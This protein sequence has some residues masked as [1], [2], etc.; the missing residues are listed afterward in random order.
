MVV[1]NESTL[2]HDIFETLY[3]LAT[4]ITY[5][6]SVEPTITAAF[7]DGAH[8]PFP[9][10]VVEPIDVNVDMIMLG[11]REAN[12]TKMR[13]I[14]ASIIIYT[15]KNEDLDLISDKLDTSVINTQITGI[16]LIDSA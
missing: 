4:A 10:I 14:N 15:K 13:T 5:G 2:R 11:A 16:S 6:T 12:N 9:Q 8:A 7:I 1:I 3:D